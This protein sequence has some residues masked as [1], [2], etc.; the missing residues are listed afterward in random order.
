MSIL[1]DEDDMKTK[2]QRT[3]EFCGWKITGHGWQDHACWCPKTFARVYK[4]DRDLDTGK[5]P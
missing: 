3:C 2:V 4:N 1:M 5:K